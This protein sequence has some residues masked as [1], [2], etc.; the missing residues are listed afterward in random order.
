MIGF[1]IR[2]IGYGLL[3]GVALRIALTLWTRLGLDGAANTTTLR[4]EGSLALTVAPFVLALAGWGPLRPLA[5]FSGWF[6]AGAAVTAPFAVGR[7]LG[8]V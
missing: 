6:L 7:A 3:L 4:D 1:I 2:L 5:V 8:L